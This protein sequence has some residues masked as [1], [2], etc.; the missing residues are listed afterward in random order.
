MKQLRVNNFNGMYY[1]CSDKNEK[2][3]AI[4]KEEMPEGIEQGDIIIIS[5]EGTITKK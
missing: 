1:I 3:F 2:Y 5:D 4:P